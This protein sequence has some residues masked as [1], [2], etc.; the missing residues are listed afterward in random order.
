MLIL[1]C[2]VKV[3]LAVNSLFHGMIMCYVDLFKVLTN[4]HLSFQFWL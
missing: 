1:C 4:K 3:A 2:V